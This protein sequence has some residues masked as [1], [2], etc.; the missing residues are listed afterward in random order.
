MSLLFV[1][2]E[3]IPNVVEPS[4]GIG[5]ILYCLLEHSFSTREDDEQRAL[6]SFPVPIAPTKVLVLPISNNEQ[7]KPFLAK[8]GMFSIRC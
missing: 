6:L 3:F 1:V 8:T 2:R 5:R 7:F 4:F